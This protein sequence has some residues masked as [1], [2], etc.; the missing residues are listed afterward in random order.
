MPFA[1]AGDWRFEVR[2]DTVK[3]EVYNTMVE[4]FGPDP[5]S[6]SIPFELIRQ[7]DVDL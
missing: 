1:G 6:N 2:E 7:L 4:Q 5:E 3:G